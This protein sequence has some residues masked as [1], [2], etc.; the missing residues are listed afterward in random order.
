LHLEL[1]LQEQEKVHAISSALSWMQEPPS[2]RSAPCNK[3]KGKAKAM[4]DDE[5]EEEATQKFR[6]ELED[7]V[8]PTTFDDKLLASLLLPPSE[9]YEGDIGLP[10]GAKIWHGRK[11][12]ITLVS[13]A[14]RVLVLEKN[15][16]IVIV[17]LP[18]TWLITAG[19]RLV[20]V[21]AG[22]VITS[23]KAACGMVSVLERRR[24]IHLCPYLSW[25]RY[26]GK[27]KA[28]ALLGDSEQAGTK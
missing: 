26:K 15:G 25:P 28:K 8:V 14:M 5:E 4:E 27:G 3:G 9:Y 20:N 7:F 12:D 10:R 18:T 2:Q 11:G 23:P 19:T 17:A 6:K 22:A 16:A 13:P 21:L 24:N 1:S